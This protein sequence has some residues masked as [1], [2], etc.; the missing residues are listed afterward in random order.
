MAG[1]SDKP[2]S[3]LTSIG[4]SR[5]HKE[6]L[7]T[8]LSLSGTFQVCA[9][10]GTTAV[11]SFDNLSELGPICD[12]EDLWLHVDAAYAGSA[13]MCPEMRHVMKGIEVSSTNVM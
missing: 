5:S 12:R 4:I 10:L 11:C 2:A 9:T 13:M 1:S 3:S 7:Y 6:Q 8:V